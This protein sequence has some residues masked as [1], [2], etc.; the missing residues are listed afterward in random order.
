VHG[1][2]AILRAPSVPSV[3]LPLLLDWVQT[4]PIMDLDRPHYITLAIAAAVAD[5]RPT[6]R[7]LRAVIRE[8]RLA[9]GW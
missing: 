6:L 7:F 9:L 4:M 3:R 1:H 5:V 2:A 8:K